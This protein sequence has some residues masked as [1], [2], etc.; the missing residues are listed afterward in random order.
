MPEKAV[1]VT[2]L[3]VG[4]GIE[5]MSELSAVRPTML[6]AISED[7]SLILPA[8]VGEKPPVRDQDG[9]AFRDRRI[10]EPANEIVGDDATRFDES[11]RHAP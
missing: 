2:D 9:L 6:P 10:V 7:G 11:H 4:V 5:V 3:P 1:H 8:G